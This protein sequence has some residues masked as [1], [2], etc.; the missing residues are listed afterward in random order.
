MLKTLNMDWKR[1]LAGQRCVWWDGKALCQHKVG[2]SG[3][4]GLR[5][6]TKVSKATLET[7]K[8][9]T[10]N[11]LVTETLQPLYSLHI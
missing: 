11:E 2:R 6:G 1:S 4:D 9:S 5:K 7:G 10:A 3:T 8:E